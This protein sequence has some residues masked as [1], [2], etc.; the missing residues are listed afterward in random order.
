MRKQIKS[1][2]QEQM[3]EVFKVMLLKGRYDQIVQM[4][5]DG[6]PIIGTLLESLYYLKQK[7][8]LDRV[9]EEAYVVDNSAR[10]FL[11]AYYGEDAYGRYLALLAKRENKK[12][13][14]DRA[15]IRLKQEEEEKR[16]DQEWQ[17]E[18]SLGLRPELLE[19]T[20]SN[21]RWGSLVQNFGAE[22]V[23]EA[24]GDNPHY[25]P[26]KRALP[27]DFLYAKGDFSQLE[28][29]YVWD[30]R[31]HGS[32]MVW[33]DHILQFTGGAEALFALNHSNVD[34]ALVD[35][36]Y[37]HLF[38]QDGAAAYKRLECIKA[39][40]DEDLLSLYRQNRESGRQ[41]IKQSGSLKLKTALFFGR[42]N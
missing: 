12:E 20:L 34:Q 7:E 32:V 23:Y 17:K 18:L 4:V 2:S 8:V 14:R 5:Q 29:D 37:K 9:L 27:K 22:A 33:V 25:A 21:Q 24:I 26:I 15:K 38:V 28:A 41:W 6:Y 11:L 3:W 39:L 19:C 1:F 10:A 42:L 36:G 31:K 30:A 35:R 16:Q 40:T 13:E